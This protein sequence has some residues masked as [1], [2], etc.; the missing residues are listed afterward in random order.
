MSYIPQYPDHWTTE[1]K[2]QQPPVPAI[3][4]HALKANKRP[5]GYAPWPKDKPKKRKAARKA[6]P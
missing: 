5:I 4:V 2:Y 1:S 6:N 3:V